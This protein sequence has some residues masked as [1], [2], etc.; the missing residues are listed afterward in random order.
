MIRKFENRMNTGLYLEKS[1]NLS[2]IIGNYDNSNETYDSNSDYKIEPYGD[3]KKFL[4]KS[5]KQSY[6]LGIIKN[7]LIDSNR[8]EFNSDISDKVSVG[9]RIYMTSSSCDEYPVKH[10]YTVS[11]IVNN[12][13]VEID[14]LLYQNYDNRECFVVYP[15]E[16]PRW[17]HKGATLLFKII[18]VSNDFE[19]NIDGNIE[20][21]TVTT[22]DNVIVIVQHVV[23]DPVESYFI[24]DINTEITDISTDFILTANSEQNQNGIIEVNNIGNSVNIPINEINNGE[25]IRC[26]D[27]HVNNTTD[28][29]LLYDKLYDKKNG[30]V[31]AVVNT[32]VLYGNNTNFLQ[33]FKPGDMIIINDLEYKI[34]KVVSNVQLI[35]KNTFKSA[36]NDSEVYLTSSLHDDVESIVYGVYDDQDGNSQGN[37]K[38]IMP[39][40]GNRKIF[41][42]FGV[43]EFLQRNIR[44]NIIKLPFSLTNKNIYKLYMNG[45]LLTKEKYTYDTKNNQIKIIDETVLKMFNNYCY[46]IYYDIDKQNTAITKEYAIF[47]YQGYKSNFLSKKD[48]LDSLY[49]FMFY[50]NFSESLGYNYYEYKDEIL[51]RIKRKRLDKNHKLT[52][53]TYVTNDSANTESNILTN[54]VDNVIRYN[55][56]FR[57][58]RYNTDTGT[59][60]VYNQCEINNPASESL[61]DD[62]NIIT[63]TIDFR[64]KI[65][66]SDRIF[67]NGDW[68]RFELFGLKFIS[69]L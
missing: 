7:G 20:L 1:T 39:I 64:D 61:A 67:G 27:F 21:K 31:E 37:F 33:D 14:G 24:T 51:D 48:Y 3:G 8:I 52:F 10:I 28:G 16:I 30:T 49:T 62:A 40:R 44:G 17:I 15:I 34:D 35:I 50:N 4:L 59:F 47:S 57:L 29:I 18:H 38:N 19:I 45:E 63:Y 36:I 66:L 55:K 5:K 9:D 54:D 65:T 60:V 42:K 53:S 58:I 23:E 6:T 25:F 13:T 46:F 26:T 43:K 22:Y 2:V 11:S 68:G 69:I 56:D 12:T 41:Y 32:N